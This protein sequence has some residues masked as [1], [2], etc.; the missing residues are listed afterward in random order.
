MT[1][2]LGVPSKGRLM[3]QTTDWFAERGVMLTRTGSDREYAGRVADYIGKNV[4][5]SPT[6]TV[7]IRNG[8]K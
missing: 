5:S 6:I 3:D 1:I 7:R 4:T 2:K 8:T